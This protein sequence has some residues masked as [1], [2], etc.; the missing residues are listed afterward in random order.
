MNTINEYIG[1][2]IND[3]NCGDIYTSY[4]GD[5]SSILYKDGS[6]TLKLSELPDKYRPVKKS[7]FIKDGNNIL[8]SF[9]TENKT[10]RNGILGFLYK[11]GSS[12]EF[13]PIQNN[14]GDENS[15]IELHSYYSEL[16]NTRLNHKMNEYYNLRSL[17]DF[18][19]NSTIIDLIGISDDTYTDVINL[20]TVGASIFDPDSI[21]MV[22]IGVQYS[23]KDGYVNSTDLSFNPDENFTKE[24]GD[25]TIEFFDKCI[26]LFSNNDSV[27]ECLISYC[28]IYYNK[29]V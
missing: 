9:I 1:L 22:K 25:I 28:H 17:R 7:D 29:I 27:V 18:V 14:N 26:R 11:D 15:L 3:P 24:Y 4:D 2:I 20:N 19:S 5:T 6:S 12:Y 10:V 8:E 13:E 16:L 23:D 21:S